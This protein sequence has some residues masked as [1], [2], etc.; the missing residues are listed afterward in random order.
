[1]T[2]ILA[3]NHTLLNEFG[4]NI[5][6][7][8]VEN[9]VTI[10]EGDFVVVNTRTWLA[11]LPKKESGY[12]SVGRAI[13]VISDQNGTTFVICKDGIYKCKNTRNGGDRIL[14]NDVMRACYFESDNTV[15]LDNI[16]STK[17]GNIISVYKKDVIIRVD[18]NEGSGMEW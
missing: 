1:M 5:T 17:A 10:K 2:N 6:M 18:V 11:T 12:Y 16:N 4:E 13:R 3:R 14:K 8:P 15:S 7:F 9:G